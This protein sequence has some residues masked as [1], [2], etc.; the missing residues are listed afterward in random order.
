MGVQPDEEHGV[1][2]I[3]NYIDYYLFLNIIYLLSI[4]IWH[5]RPDEEDGVSLE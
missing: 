2:V 1:L 5:A 4:I 3:Y